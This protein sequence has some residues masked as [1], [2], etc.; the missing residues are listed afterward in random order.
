MLKIISSLDFYA[1]TTIHIVGVIKFVRLHNVYN[2]NVEGKEWHS[3]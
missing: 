3:A 1:E 2:Y